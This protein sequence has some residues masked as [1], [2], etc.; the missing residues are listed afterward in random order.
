MPVSVYP[1]VLLPYHIIPK[2][3]QAAGSPWGRWQSPASRD[4][5]LARL[6]VCGEHVRHASSH[7]ICQ[8]SNLAAVQDSTRLVA[9]ISSGECLSRISAAQRHATTMWVRHVK[10]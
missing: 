6:G 9:Y 8:C 4:T 1:M 7:R 3:N 5:G 2:R 10:T